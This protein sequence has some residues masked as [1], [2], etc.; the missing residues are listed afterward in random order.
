[1]ETTAEWFTKNLEKLKNDPGFHFEVVI[2]DITN[3]ICKVMEEKG[4]DNY[5]LSKR[6]NIALVDVIYILGGHEDLT[7]KQLCDIDIALNQ[8]E[9]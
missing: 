3:N 5:E 7:I 1:M 4:V 6:L 8:K 2:S 9:E